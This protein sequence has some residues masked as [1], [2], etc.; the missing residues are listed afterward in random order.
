MNKIKIEQPSKKELEDLGVRYWNTWGC[1]EERFDWEYV[2]GET[3]YILEGTARIKTPTGEVAIT[4]GDLVHFPK[5]LKCV[6]TVT[7]A[8]KKVYKFE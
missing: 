6:W 3:C 1:G 8:I 7:E 5:G 4:K 2:R